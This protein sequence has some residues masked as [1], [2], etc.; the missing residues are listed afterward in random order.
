M[1]LVTEKDE[2]CLTADCLTGRPSGPAYSTGELLNTTLLPLAVSGVHAPSLLVF[3]RLL[4]C[5]LFHRC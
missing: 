3:R 5:E 1:I 2:S 4:K